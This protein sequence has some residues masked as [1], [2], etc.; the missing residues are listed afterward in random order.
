MSS[1]ASANQLTALVVSSMGLE[2]TVYGKKQGHALA[3]G[4]GVLLMLIPY[5]IGDTA[6]LLALGVALLLLP[7]LLRSRAS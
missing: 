4:C 6:M 1:D 3:M 7:F 5:A 2:Y